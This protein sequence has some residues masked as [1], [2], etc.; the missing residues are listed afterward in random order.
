MLCL[1]G[2]AIEAPQDVDL[3]SM[4]KCLSHVGVEKD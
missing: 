2:E 3:G 1:L 4:R